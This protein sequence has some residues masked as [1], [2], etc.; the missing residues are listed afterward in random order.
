MSTLKK[1]LGQGPVRVLELIVLQFLVI[2]I[3][4]NNEVGTAELPAVTARKVTAATGARPLVAAKDKPPSAAARPRH[5]RPCDTDCPAPEL[6]LTVIPQPAAL[7][8]SQ[9]LQI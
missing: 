2:V 4:P 1:F 9:R 5:E 8:L 3:S 7:Q 6:R